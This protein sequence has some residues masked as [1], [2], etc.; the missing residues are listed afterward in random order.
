MLVPILDFF[1][2]ALVAAELFLGALIWLSDRK[3][4]VNIGF[5][6]LALCGALWGGAVFMLGHPR[7]NLELWGIISFV[8][9]ILLPISLLLFV[10]N[11]PYRGGLVK[12]WQIALVAGMALGLLVMNGLGLIVGNY[13]LAA[14]IEYE[15]RFGY[16]Y[17]FVPYFV[18]TVLWGLAGIIHKYFKASPVERTQTLYVM[19][20]VSAALVAGAAAGLLLP[21]FGIVK[22]TFFGPILSGMIVVVFVGYGVLH[23][24][25]MN[26]KLAAARAGAF[27]II[28]TA[29]L[30]GPMVLGYYYSWPMAMILMFA[31]ATLGP[32]LY[33]TI[34]N[35]FSARINQ[36]RELRY[37]RGVVRIAT[38][39][40]RHKKLHKLLRFIV[41]VL[42]SVLKV[43]FAEIFLEDESA[44][45]Y[46]WVNVRRDEYALDDAVAYDVNHPLVAYM[47]NSSGPTAGSAAPAAVRPYLEQNERH[48]EY[49]VPLLIEKKLIGFIILGAKNDKA[50]YSADD[51]GILEIITRQASY[52]VSNCRFFEQFRTTEDRVFDAERLAS[53]GGMAGGVVHQLSHRIAGFDY[54]M[55][56]LDVLI[57]TLSERFSNDPSLSQVLEKYETA[58]I[59][60]RNNMHG[61]SEMISEMLN[62]I[63]SQRDSRMVYGTFSLKELLHLI[64]GPL[65]TKHQIPDAFPLV[66]NLGKNDEICGVRTHIV[67]AMINLI[68]NAYDAVEEKRARLPTEE[69]RK[70]FMPHISVTLIQ[71]PQKSLIQVSDNGIGIRGPEKSN[72]FKMFYST[73]NR[74]G[75]SGTGI[76]MYVVRRIIEEFHKGRIWFD[77]EHQVGTKFYIELPKPV[78]EE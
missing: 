19:F 50:P 3:N 69:Q 45:S 4:P 53:I 37:R 6:S 44:S 58:H 61:M 26:V 5:G 46:K 1:S 33:R 71:T 74:A 63:R 78:V 72:I 73:K 18:A 38:G 10:A 40:A 57:E 25:V 28:Y 21:M 65:K 14:P 77:S 43:S 36:E 17:L 47:Q 56:Q 64:I 13:H 34:E 51:R 52:A 62:F 68:D 7:G 23:Y 8:G 41:Y 31:L 54:T 49:L 11:Y 59:M 48:I 60:F 32:V 66:T 22:F 55:S 42:R 30:S 2:V 9:P 20:G 35:R 70:N 75:K 39:L 27:L 12:S 16:Y 67:E 15:R 29:I 76:G 24:Q